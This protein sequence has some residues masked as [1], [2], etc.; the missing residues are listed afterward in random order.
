VP[1]LKPKATLSAG[2]ERIDA[3]VFAP[4]GRHLIAGSAAGAV[5]VWDVTNAGGDSTPREPKAV[6]QWGIGAVTTLAVAADGLTAAAGGSTGRVMVWD[7]E[8]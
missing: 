5:R 1:P 8:A 7:L 6:Y 2:A 3:L 4:D